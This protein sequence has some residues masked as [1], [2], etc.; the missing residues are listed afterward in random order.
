[1]TNGVGFQDIMAL[2]RQ[3]SARLHHYFIGVEHL[4]IALTRLKGGLT[5]AALEQHG[6]SGRFVRYSILE[7]IGRYEDRRFWPGFPET[8]RARQVLQLAQGHA[9]S[10]EILERALLLAILDEGDNAV[11]RV[12]GETG[13]DPQALR[14][15]AANWDAPLHAQV[16]DVPIRGDVTLDRERERVLQVMFRDY[17]EVEVVRELDGGYSSAQVL[18]VRPRRIDRKWDAPVVVKLDDRYATLYERRRYDLHVAGTL[19]VGAAQLLGAPVAPDDSHY[20]GL[21]YKFVGHLDATQPVSL[22]EVALG[23]HTQRMNQLIRGLFQTFGPAWWE[24]RTP[25]QFGV[26]RE[27]EHVLPPALVV[28]VLPGAQVGSTGHVLMPL[29]NWS[30]S[31]HVLPGEVVALK[32]FAVQKLDVEE[33]VLYLAAGAQPEAIHRSSKVE[34]RGLG[35]Q[36]DSYL[37]GEIVDVLVG[38]VVSTRDDLL[39]LY[40]QALE[41]DF[42]LRLDH[43]PPGHD[44]VPDL[45]N[46]LR[47]VNQLLERQVAGYLST[48]HGDMHLANVLVGPQGNPWLIDFAQAREGHTLFDWALLEVSVLVHIVAGL[49]PD[50]WA[51]V[52]GVIALLDS[53]NRGE[54]R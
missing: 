23:Q 22:R 47:E 2:A 41:P 32:R 31:N 28:E 18:L 20:G 12:L 34:V 16:P 25:F 7:T 14:H 10:G 51:G 29:G 24:Q 35:L 9:G 8:P 49:M 37:R 4:F 30:R 11:M 38:R 33:D 27:Y 44:G 43:I 46:P 48:I 53:I 13:V 19:P 17:S 21:R 26:W 52:W 39:L 54:E 3:E 40:L 50:G 5:N 1:M 45:P 15:T 42:D 36:R 6:L